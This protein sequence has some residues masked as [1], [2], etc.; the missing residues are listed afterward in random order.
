MVLSILPY[1]GTNLV[2][3]YPASPQR[4]CMVLEYLVPCGMVGMGNGTREVHAAS[5][6]YECQ[7]PA[8]AALAAASASS[9]DGSMSGRTRSRP[10]GERS[11]FACPACMCTIYYLPWFPRCT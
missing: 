11:I 8:R 1:H 4:A 2:L 7:M 6:T 10:R 5:S 9:I 3:E